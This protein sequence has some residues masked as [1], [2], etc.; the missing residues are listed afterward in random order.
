LKMSAWRA[1]LRAIMEP[2][3]SAIKFDPR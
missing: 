3:D 2:H 1:K